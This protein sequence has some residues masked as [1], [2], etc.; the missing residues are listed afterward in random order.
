MTLTEKEIASALARIPPPPRPR[1]RITPGALVYWTWHYPKLVRRNGARAHWE[2]WLGRRRFV[3]A[4]KDYNPESPATIATEKPLTVSLLAGRKHASLAALALLSLQ[5]SSRRPVYP[6]VHDD[7]TL[8]ALYRDEL[9]RFFPA[10]RFVSADE[11]REALDRVLPEKSFPFLR[12]TRL[13]YLH[14]R[15][16][17]D[18]HAAG[19]GW[20]LVMDSD[21]I[22]YRRPD[23]LL[24]AVDG[25][26][27]AHMVDC[28]TNYG[29]GVRLLEDLTGLT[30]HPRLNAG[31]LN[32]NSSEIDWDFLEYA[33]SVILARAGFSYYLEQALLAVLMAKHGARA[34]TAGQYLVNPTESQ[35][36]NRLEVAHHFVDRSILHLYR[37]AWQGVLGQ[38]PPRL[39]PAAPSIGL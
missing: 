36:Q 5:Q 33:A 24:R 38:V 27:W 29:C 22:F 17:T 25:C 28:Q 3:R 39:A 14:L 18:I 32:I 31:L 8:A 6:V 30:V 23:E 11:T 35:T 26:E 37:F 21:V 13:G 19:T 2:A 16:L 7:G 4:V 15:K 1:P 9:K 10:T 34:F 20:T 12:G